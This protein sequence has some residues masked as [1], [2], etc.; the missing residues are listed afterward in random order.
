MADD[1][2][3]P[4]IKAYA[5]HKLDIG[6][7]TLH[8]EES[9]SLTGQPVIFLHG[10]PGSSCQ[11]YQRRFFNPKKYRLIMFDQRGAGASTPLADVGDNHTQ[12]LLSDIEQIRLKF[13]IDRW[14]VFGGSWGTALGLLYAQQ[15]P[16][17]VSGLILRGVFLARQ[18][19]LDWFY[20]DGGVNRMIPKQWQDFVEIVPLSQRDRPLMHYYRCLTGD[21]KPARETAARYFS[22]WRM[23]VATR[24]KMD[25]LPD[26]SERLLA[27]TRI[28]C[29][30]IYH[31]CFIQ[32]N[33]II[34]NMGKLK[35][36][37][38]IIVHGQN[39]LVCP[40]ESA[41]IL[42][43]AWPK[44]TL[45][46]LEKTGHFDAEKATKSALVKALDSW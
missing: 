2:L 19:D 34:A 44:S 25:K 4:E 22:R 9:G 21:D 6:R 1:V 27:S 8:I 14:L 37:S 11:P 42:H 40:P 45:Q 33:Q 35:D 31:R 36:I 16:E 39:D 5:T 3:H 20:A 38:G 30:Y 10:G 13:E 17:Q 32:E 7:H 23:C 43:Q 41:H 15:F 26:F 46:M 24:G 12:A 29:H 18:R 28:E